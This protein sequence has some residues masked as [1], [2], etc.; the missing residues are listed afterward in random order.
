ML[1]TLY[2]PRSPARRHKLL[3][4]GRSVFAPLCH[5]HV[6]K[7][8]DEPWVPAF[9]LDLLASRLYSIC[10]SP[11]Y[12]LHTRRGQRFLCGHESEQAL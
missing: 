6:Y 7:T 5:Q 11:L 12:W 1:H 4:V 2:A 3:W 8:A 10:R 9:G